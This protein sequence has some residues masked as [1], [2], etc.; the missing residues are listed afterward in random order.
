MRV[1]LRCLVLR[2]YITLEPSLQEGN[3]NRNSLSSEYHFG[4]LGHWKIMK[5][6]SKKCRLLNLRGRQIEKRS[7]VKDKTS[8]KFQEVNGLFKIDLGNKKEIMITNLDLGVN[9]A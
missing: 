3:L 2:G 4:K 6:S 5:K 8:K 1:I 7:R 9:I